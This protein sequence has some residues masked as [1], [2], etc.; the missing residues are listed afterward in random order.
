ML[1]IK[2][3]DNQYINYNEVCNNNN[4]NNNKNNTNTNHNNN[5]LKT[6]LIK[7]CF[8][9]GKSQGWVTT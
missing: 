5:N 2:Q 4:N 3:Q 8:A 1:N 6:I 9:R 7:E